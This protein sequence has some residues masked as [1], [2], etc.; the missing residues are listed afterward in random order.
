MIDPK[1][2]SKLDILGLSTNYNFMKDKRQ[3]Q[4]NISVIFVLPL[5]RLNRFLE[6]FPIFV[7]CIA[8]ILVSHILKKARKGVMGF[9]LMKRK[10]LLVSRD[11]SSLSDYQFKVSLLS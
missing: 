11:R 6:N 3:K 8:I 7:L 4:R 1:V 5:I 10:N 2:K 9:F